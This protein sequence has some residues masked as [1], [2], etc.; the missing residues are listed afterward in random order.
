[1]TN[2]LIN[3]GLGIILT[4][5]VLLLWHRGKMICNHL[6]VRQNQKHKRLIRR[7]YFRVYYSGSYAWLELDFG[8]VSHGELSVLF[9]CT[10]RFINWTWRAR[11]V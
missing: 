1:M 3:T 10:N 8:R 6:G 5:L 9:G 7:K 11:E 2:I 4:Y